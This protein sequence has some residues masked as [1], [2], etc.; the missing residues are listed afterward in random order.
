M[1]GMNRPPRWMSIATLGALALWVTACGGEY[2]NST[3]N[4]TTEFNTAID[5]VWDRL[6]FWGTIVFVGVE[7]ALIYTIFRF[8]KRPGTRGEPKQ[9]HGNTTIEIVWTVIPA[10]ILVF[11]AIPT[12]RTIFQTQ[13]KAAPDALQ[14]EVIGHQWWWEFKY[15]QYGIT[16][17]NELYLPTGRTVNFQLK[18]V[19]VLHSFW[20]PQ[21]GGKRDLITNKTNYLWFTPDAKLP[22]SAWNGACVEFCGPSHANMKF[23]TYTVT[24]D[25]FERWAAHQQR[26]AVFPVAMA[27]AV[28]A[29]AAGT[30]AADGRVLLRPAS[31][32][33]G[34]P[35]PQP[36][37]DAGAPPAEG[38][39]FPAERIAREF[40]HVIPQTPIPAGVTFDESLLAAG[41]PTRGEQ[42]YS[43]SSCIGC[44]VITGNRM[45]MGIIGPDLTHLASR[46]TIAAGLYPND[47][48]HLA[49]WLKSA[50][51][52]KP[53]SIMPTLGKGL[54]DPKTK[55]VVT[56]GGLT[57][58]EIADIVAYLLALK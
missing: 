26:P 27:A 15:P 1:V 35:T 42:L 8:R 25:E 58:A 11:I 57:D 31:F 21:L 6:L 32:A 45:S 2:P 41:D 54:T 20:I 10:V 44:H 46:H 33:Q 5:A 37:P 39:V 16:T 22:T 23:R 52:L 9:V 36:A 40:P 12:V 30:A 48:K 19:D 13:A 17:A 38:Y 4:H 50:P 3:F 47:A 28:D 7:V 53:G 14:V 56:A 18:T 43:R 55:M 49:Y 51:H 29:P 24:A 34:E